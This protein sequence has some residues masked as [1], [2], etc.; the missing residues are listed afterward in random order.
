M[1][2]SHNP[3]PKAIEML[4]ANPGKI[5]WFCLSLNSNPQAVKWLESN[6]DKINWY[7]LSKNPNAMHIL[8]PIDYSTMKETMQP[9]CKELVEYV[10][11]PLRISRISSNFE[12]ELEEYLDL[13]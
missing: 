1:G 9:F 10:L 2:L 5:D 7:N 12:L 4:E 8:A 13:I 6:P 11:H 3:N